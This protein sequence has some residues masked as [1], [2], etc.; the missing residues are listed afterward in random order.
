MQQSRSLRWNWASSFRR[1]QLVFGWWGLIVVLGG[2]L[3]DTNVSARTWD[4]SAVLWFWFGLN[5]LGFIGSY[6]IAREFLASGM[7]FIWAVIIGLAF[8]LTW[9]I[10]FSLK[11]EQYY[12]KLPIVWHLAF[13]LAYLVN[14]YYMDRRLWWL[15]G[16]EALWG[17]FAA[18]LALKILTLAAI[19]SHGN[20]VLGLSS[21]IP[22]LLAVLPIWKERYG[23]S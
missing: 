15:A 14:G 2:W 6:L 7:L 19:T 11:I 10:I 16:W 23:N 9:I 22:L 4:I 5:A 17:L 3:V 12:E 21:G 1:I 20:L 18:L 8:L 13:A